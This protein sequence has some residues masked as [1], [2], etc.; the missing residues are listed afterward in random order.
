MPHTSLLPWLALARLPQAGPVTQ[1]KLLQAAGSMAELLDA[2]PWLADRY[3]NNEQAALWTDFCSGKANA[4]LR[5]QAERDLEMLARCDAKLIHWEH[6]DYPEL[7]KS[8]YDPPL[9]L[10]VRGDASLLAQPQLAI[11]GSRN[12][13]V[14][15]LELAYEF[16]Q[17]ASRAGWLVTSGLALGID[18]QAHRGA[19]ELGAPTIA[20]M[21]TGI[22]DVY[23]KRHRMLAEQIL[24]AG[25]ALI[26]EFSPLTAPLAQ[27]FPRR[28]RIISGLSAGVLV[29]EASVQSGSLITALS[30]VEQGREVFAL[31]G[32]VKSVYHRGCHALI[33]QGAHLVENIEELLDILPRLTAQPALASTPQVKEK[34]IM[35]E[36]AAAL[37]SA[38]DYAPVSI[39]HLVERTDLAVDE[40]AAL[41]SQLEVDGVISQQYGYYSRL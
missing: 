22:D 39:D 27:F 24:A 17:D 21:A 28:N 41:L 26:T 13:S 1:R 11:V 4:V 19:V 30:A 32:S 20:V 3:L 12:A 36:A 18:A 15:G 31:P 5:H 37:Y 33:R 34:V 9:T 8:I 10:F 40:L 16:A 2:S 23:P 38:I 35:S 14:S 29:V 7:L 6:S 25:G